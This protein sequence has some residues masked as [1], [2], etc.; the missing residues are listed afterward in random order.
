MLAACAANN[1]AVEINAS[2]HRL[3]LDWRELRAA[4]DA[5][6]KFSINPDAHSTKGL[7]DVRFGVGVARKGWLEAGD[8]INTLDTAEITRFLARKPPD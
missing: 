3:D 4:R 5:G 7:G 8:V 1:V 2:P 6:C